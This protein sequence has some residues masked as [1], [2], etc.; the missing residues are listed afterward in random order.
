MTKEQLDKI[1]DY[2][3]HAITDSGIS[4]RAI[5]GHPNGVYVTTSD[6]HTEYGYAAEEAEARNKMMEKRMRKYETMMEDIRGPELYGD[7]DAE[8]TFIGWGSTYGA[9]REA[10]DRLRKNGMKVNFLK[11]SDLWPFPE[12]KARPFLE[13]AKHL[14]AV[15]NNFTGQ[16]A[17]VIRKC[18]G[19]GVDSK[20]LKYSGRPFSPEEIMANFSARGGSAV[21]RKE[22]AKVNV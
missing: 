10:V 18:T 14:I 6:E 19:T 11:F 8:F 5:P 20:I 15:E 12:A 21:G 9:I 13:K 22:E 4:P 3:R 2:K 16:L 1:N 7:K 17:N